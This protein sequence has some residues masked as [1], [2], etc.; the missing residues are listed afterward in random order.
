MHIHGGGF[1]AL[2]SRSAQIY[3]RKW[4]IELGVPIFS[5]DYRMPDEHYFPTAP[6]DC[7]RV[8]EFL[9]KSIHKYLNINPKKIV[10]A[11]DSAGGNLCFATTAVIMRMMKELPLPHG[12]LSIY[13]AN[14]LQR[15]FS[16]SKIYSFTDPVLSPNMLLLCL[17]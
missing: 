2:S 8:Y 16:P 14:D 9:I 4:A 15:K 10:I 5:V 17:N 13:P 12:I 11:G 1:F 3:T 7:Y 6:N